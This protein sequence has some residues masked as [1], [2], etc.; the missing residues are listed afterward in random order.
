MASTSTRGGSLPPRPHW[1][2]RQPTTCHLEN[3]PG[4]GGTREAAVSQRPATDYDMSILVPLPHVQTF[5]QESDRIPNLPSAS[6]KGRKEAE[7][8][9]RNGRM[10][11]SQHR[12]AGNASRKRA[13]CWLVR[14]WLD[15]GA[16]IMG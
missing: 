15:A 1:V 9:D 14:A 11:P 12:L 6:R 5:G 8:V 2:D 10:T 16:A 7:L 4:P 13:E 3:V